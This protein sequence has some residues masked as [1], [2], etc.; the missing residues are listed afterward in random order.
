LRF[1]ASPEGKFRG[2]FRLLANSFDS[3]GRPLLR[4]ASTVVADL[5]P[6]SYR[7][8][9]SQGLRFRQELDVPVDAGFLRL[10]VGDTFSSAIGTLELPL[11]IPLSKDDAIARRGKVLPPVEPE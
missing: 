6:E 11:P 9:F 2:R 5:K 7:S 4:A 8:M 10:G 3:E 1:E